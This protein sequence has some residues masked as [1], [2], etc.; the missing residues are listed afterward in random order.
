[1]PPRMTSRQRMLAALRHERPDRVP[2]APWGLGWLPRDA[3]VTRELVARCDPWLEFRRSCNIVGGAA[4]PAEERRE[5]D[6][7]IT[8]VHAP[9]RDLVA[10]RT[11]TAQTTAA[12]EYL[13]KSVEDVEALLT[14][15]YV[16]PRVDVEAFLAFKA[17]VGEDGLAV[18][19]VPDGILFPNE[20]L[21][22]EMASYLWA[23]EPDVIA[24]MVRIAAERVY[25]VLDEA[26]AAG[27]DCIRI[28]GGEYA[29]QLM[30]PSAWD[31]LVA[32]YDTPLVEMIRRHGA[33]AHYHN[34]GN[35]QH[36]LGRIAALGIDSLD[37]V[38]QPPYGDTEMDEAYRCIGDRVCLVGGL[39]DMEVLETRPLDEVRRMGA[40]L[41][42]RVGPCGWMLGGTSSG[43]YTERAA[44]AFIALAEVSAEMA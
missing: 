43:I 44:R 27:V 20:V 23:T 4:Y 11:T 10:V 40:D 34:H 33:V 41:I 37:P 17:Q 13:C 30:G 25:D 24:R 8:V 18:M 1:M 6:R 7:H 32:P 39:D 5:G 22:T 29:T 42:E 2:V 12:T 31:E 36:F 14:I 26:C 19:G 15:P 21:G 9:G 28:V 38:E 35:M 3:P 16:R